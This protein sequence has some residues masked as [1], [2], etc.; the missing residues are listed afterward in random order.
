MLR[1]EL[2]LNTAERHRLC[3]FGNFISDF[4]HIRHIEIAFSMSY[5]EIMYMYWVRNNF[6]NLNSFYFEKYF[7]KFSAGIHS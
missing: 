1:S 4:E 6:G 3:Y 2:T 5:I 7:E